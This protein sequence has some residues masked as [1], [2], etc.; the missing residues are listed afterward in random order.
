MLS[1]KTIDSKCLYSFK[2]FE[3]RF[4]NRPTGVV[5]N[6]CIGQ[7]STFDSRLSCNAFADRIN[8]ID[9]IIVVA[10]LNRTEKNAIYFDGSVKYLGIV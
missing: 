9:N 5:S 2:P 10:K 3:N 8:P 1:F 7:R 4:N 6:I